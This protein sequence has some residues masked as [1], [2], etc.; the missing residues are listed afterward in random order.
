MP[1]KSAGILV[2]RKTQDEYEYLLVH[3]GGP[4]WVKKD[5]NSWSIPKGEF[6]EDEQP[7][8]A[9]KR[10]FEEETGFSIKGEFIELNPVKQPGGKLIYS[11]A[12]KSDIDSSRVKSNLFKMEWPPR[13]GAYKEFPEIDRAEWFD[14]ETAKQKILSGQIPIIENL[15]NKLIG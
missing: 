5:F 2:F 6:E 1:K 11:W 3:P 8:A 7:L 13:S 12:V 9:A 15:K 10:E 4:F 14:F